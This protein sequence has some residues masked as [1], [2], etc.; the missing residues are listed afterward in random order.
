MPFHGPE[1][2]GMIAFKKDGFVPERPFPFFFAL[3]KE[4]TLLLT[5]CSF[6]AKSFPVATSPCF[7]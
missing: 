7:H 1:N 4:E 6:M 2:I 3:S 5:V